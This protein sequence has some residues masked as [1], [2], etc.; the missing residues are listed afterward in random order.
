MVNLKRK[1]SFG[2]IKEVLI[3][4]LG[5]E[6][7]NRIKPNAFVKDL[8]NE[9]ESGDMLV[10]LFNLGISPGN[11]YGGENITNQGREA[12]K[13]IGIKLGN[14][15]N[16]EKCYDFAQLSQSKSAQE[17]NNQIRVKDLVYMTFYHQQLQTQ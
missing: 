4:S 9:F 10:I 16:K 12:L 13:E 1:M 2:Y 17:F 3:D 6:S 14:R 15:R 7:T 11:Y 8:S 5:L